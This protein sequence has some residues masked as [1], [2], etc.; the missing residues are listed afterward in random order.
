MKDFLGTRLVLLVLA[1][2]KSTRV[3]FEAVHT[4]IVDHRII[5]FTE[6]TLLLRFI[7]IVKRKNKFK[8]Q[9]EKSALF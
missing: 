1:V 5:F 9:S 3:E 8:Y 7:D 6:D 4:D 2:W